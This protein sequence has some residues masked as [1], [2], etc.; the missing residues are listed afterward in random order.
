MPTW[1]FTK[2]PRLYLVN[3]RNHGIPCLAT[4]E[5]MVGGDDLIADRSSYMYETD[6][7]KRGGEAVFCPRTSGKSSYPDLILSDGVGK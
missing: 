6:A 7:G 5:I 3:V 1:E 4:Q 2:L